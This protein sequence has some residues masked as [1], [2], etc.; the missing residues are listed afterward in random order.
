MQRLTI[1]GDDSVKNYIVS[2]ETLQELQEN[3]N[4]LKKIAFFIREQYLID[5]VGVD[6]K[7][8][9]IADG[10][11]FKIND[12]YDKIQ[13]TLNIICNDSKL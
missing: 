11:T 10:V 4:E 13:K 7:K 9:I 1:T 3:V 5:N 2:K 6:L 12:S 8:E